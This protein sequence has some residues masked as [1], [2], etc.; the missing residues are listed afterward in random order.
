[1]YS[2]GMKKFLITLIIILAVVA[3]F[4]Y[5]SEASTSNS[6]RSYSETEPGFDA[7]PHALLPDIAVG[8]PAKYTISELQNWVRPEGPL[9]VGIQV[10]HWKNETMPE[11]LANLERNTGATWNGMTES[12]VVLVI[13]ELVQ[14]RL[15]VAGIQAEL[16]PAA[17]PPGYIADA[18][19]SVHADGNK[20]ETIN[21]FKFSAPRRD[22]A[23][24]SQALVDIMYETYAAATGLRVDSSITRRMTSY[25]AF[26]WP[27]YEYAIHP[28]TPAIIIETGFLTSP[29]DRA[30]IVNEPERAAQGIADAVLQ[31]LQTENVERAPLPT[32]FTPQ[33]KLPI[34]GEV[35]CAPLRT[36]R[37]ASRNEYDCAPSL[38]DPRGYIYLLPNHSS[39]TIAVGSSFTANGQYMP[40]Q[41]LGT[42]FWF[43]YQVEGI[44]VDP[45]LPMD[46]SWFLR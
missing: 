16:L 44:I 22:Y 45:A 32:K 12:E 36:E 38:I 19:L 20:D 24:T 23:R 39:S 28:F 17:V 35:V 2:F 1:M 31:F 8:A 14:A 3:G 6:S 33:P 34:T 26:N 7:E 15:Q 10:G 27:R 42:Y 13:S 46:D 30:I 40:I 4:Y 41:N 21:G 5:F 37:Q 11:E 43:P 9:K 18:F 29:V 25:Y